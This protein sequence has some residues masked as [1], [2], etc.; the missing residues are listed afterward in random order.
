MCIKMAVELSNFNSDELSAL[1]SGTCYRFDHKEE[2]IKPKIWIESEL[3]I[4][5]SEQYEHI[6]TYCLTFS[7]SEELTKLGEKQEEA[8]INISGCDNARSGL[9]G[10][11]GVTCFS[12]KFSEFDELIVI[13]T[14]GKVRF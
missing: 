3:D 9:C 5:D 2:A 12:A 10:V 1:Y 11:N 13:D 14:E 8:M 4:E 6:A 7:P